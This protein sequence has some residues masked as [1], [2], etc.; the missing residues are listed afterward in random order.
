MPSASSAPVGGF[1]PTKSSPMQGVITML[2]PLSPTQTV[3]RSDGKRSASPDC[4]IQWHRYKASPPAA[5]RTSVSRTKG[6]QRSSSML[7][8]AFSSSTPK[9]SQPN[10]HMGQLASR[11]LM[12]R[13]TPA[14]GPTM[15]CP[16]IAVGMQRALDSAIGLPSRSSSASR[17]LAFLMPA[18]VRRNL[19]LPPGVITADENLLGAYGCLRGRDWQTTQNSSA[20]ARSSVTSSKGHSGSPGNSRRP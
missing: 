13:H 9:D 18:D 16:Y 17:M 15:G 10:P 12:N 8:S 20:P 5:S 6:T 19:K 4:R 1:Q 2:P 11:P 7:G 14:P 3:S